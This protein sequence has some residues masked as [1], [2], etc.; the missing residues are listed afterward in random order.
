MSHI[1]SFT[2]FTKTFNNLNES[3]INRLIS[4]M[5][6]QTC[7]ILSAFRS[8]FG[9]ATKDDL[10]V[11]YSKNM[12]N[13][14]ELKELILQFGYEFTEVDG[15]YIENYGTDSASIDGEKS[16]FVTSPNENKN[17][18]VDMFKLAQIYNQD[19]IAYIPYQTKTDIRRDGNISFLVG[20]SDCPT[21]YPGL[22][23]VKGNNKKVYGRDGYEFYTN[24]KRRPMVFTKHKNYFGFPTYQEYLKNRY[25]PFDLPFNLVGFED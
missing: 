20:T 14:R 2:E 6:T 24:I 9:C 18:L 13:H 19:S 16:L 4:K 17:I 21:A 22:Y 12:K 7:V 5:D 8:R 25:F 10:I 11:P 1:K 15:K 3:S 23:N